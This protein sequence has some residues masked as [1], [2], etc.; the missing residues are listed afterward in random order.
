[1]Q[2]VKKLI[3][4]M[5]P[6]GFS[7]RTSFE[8]LIAFLK[9]EI[10]YRGQLHEVVTQRITTR[11]YDVL[12]AI[13]PYSAIINR[14]AHWNPHHNSFF[15]TVGHN[16]YLLNDMISFLSINKNTSY[17]HMYKLGLRIPTTVAL[18]QQDYTEIT[19][20]PKA[21]SELIFSEHEPF[22][23]KS[24]GEEV[25]YPAFLK[26]QSGGGWVGVE[27]V[28]N[29]EDLLNTYNKSGDK[30]MNLQKAIDYREFVRTVGVGPQMMPMHYNAKAKYSHDRYLRSEQQA[31]EFDFLSEAEYDE[32]KKICKIINAFYKWDH[33]SCETLI[34][35]DGICYP[36]DFANAYPDSTLISLHFYFPEL[37]KAMARWMIFCS[38]TERKKSFNFAQ[39]WNR[40]FEIMQNEELTYR[41]K[42]DLYEKIADDHFETKKFYE[43]CAEK[44]PD[45]DE[46]AWEFFAGEEFEKILTK[47][48]E[49]YFKIQEERP[50]KLAHY[51]GIHQFWLN[52]EKDRLSQGKK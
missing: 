43:F 33:N 42:L 19:K 30:P 41:E 52:C 15:M 1:M 4:V 22:D 47:E 3:G 38:V 46:K 25:G 49:Y 29:Y 34:G 35:F 37:V 13:C 27:K 5:D 48:V 11:P 23:L 51:K 39:D 14:G 8:K 21:N 32:V 6:N 17:G 26:P 28:S 24:I 50:G 7:F 44:M 20:D 36:I 12:N 10:E 45:F 2:K 18:P 40:Y 9:P 16:S 31:I